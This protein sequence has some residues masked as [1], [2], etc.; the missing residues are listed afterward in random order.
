MSRVRPTTDDIRAT[1]DGFTD[2]YA[3]IWGENL[4]VGYWDNAGA[5]VP[6]PAATDRLNSELMTRLRTRPDD[7]VLDV[8]CGIGRP[9]LR[10]A[11]EREISV[12]GVTIS[13]Y[14]VERATE[15]AQ[16]EGLTERFPVAAPYGDTLSA[17]G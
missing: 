4:H 3:R 9:A 11:R 1:Y 6:V 10:L 7:V 13:P 2:A 12:I 14:Q 16:A 17:A 8:G 5:D 15:N